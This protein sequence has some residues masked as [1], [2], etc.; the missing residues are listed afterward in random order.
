MLHG[1]AHEQRVEEEEEEEGVEG[2]RVAQVATVLSNFSTS[3]P[4]VETLAH[5]HGVLRYPPSL[6]LH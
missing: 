1:G 2:Y 3:E 5:H 4:S 6:I